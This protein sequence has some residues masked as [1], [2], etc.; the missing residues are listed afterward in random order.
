MRELV[1]MDVFDFF[2]YVTK[3]EGE[4]KDAAGSRNKTRRK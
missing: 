2:H 3:V 4:F 1:K